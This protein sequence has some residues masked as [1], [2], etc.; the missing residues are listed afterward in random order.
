MIFNRY[1][2]ICIIL[3]LF[4]EHIFKAKFFFYQTC[5]EHSSDN[6]PVNNQNTVTIWCLFRKCEVG[7]GDIKRV[8]IKDVGRDYG[9]GSVA[10]KEL[11]LFGEDDSEEKAELSPKESLFSR[12]FMVGQVLLL[13]NEQHV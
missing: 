3:F 11:S 4:S 10:G 12:D 13:K 6:P 9:S 8:T 5:K 1:K 7:D 2:F